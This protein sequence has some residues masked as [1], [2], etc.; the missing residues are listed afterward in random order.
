MDSRQIDGRDRWIEK[1]R[2][3]EKK[4]DFSGPILVKKSG[5]GPKSGNPDLVGDTGDVIKKLEI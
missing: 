2:L 5:S 3:L 1:S 4:T